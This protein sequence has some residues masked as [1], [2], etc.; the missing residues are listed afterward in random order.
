MFAVGTPNLTS[1]LNLL[2]LAT[3]VEP[4]GPIYNGPGAE[5]PKIPF[6]LRP[7]EFHEREAVDKAKKYA[8][9][10]SIRAVLLRQTQSQQSQQLNNIKKNQ[11]VALLNRVYVGSIAY[12]VK[13]DSLRQMFASFGPLKTV[14]M[15]WDPATQKHKGFAFLEFEYPEAAHLAIEQMN[16]TSF[17]GRQLKV[18][19]P[20]NLANADP[21]IADLVAEYKLQNRVYV[22]GIHLDLTEDDVAL[23][24]EAFGK[25]VFCRLLVDPNSVDRHRG[26]GYIE[27]ENTQSANDAVASMNQFNLGGQLLRV[28]KAISP[29]DGISN[30]SA[31]AL[32]P[33]AAVAAASVTAKVLSMETEQLPIN[34]TQS[35]SQ[36]N[37]SGDSTL[38]I[39]SAEIALPLGV[40]CPT[41]RSSHV[42]G[43][44]LQSPSS[45]NHSPLRQPQL[46]TPQSLCSW[47]S[48]AHQTTNASLTGFSPT[49]IPVPSENSVG[50]GKR[51][52]FVDAPMPPPPVPGILV[53][54]NMVGPEDCDDE[55]EDEVV[56]ECSQY[57]HVERVL[58]HQQLDTQTN[59]IIVKVFVHFSTYDAVQRAVEALN[60]RYFARRQIIA[61]PYDLHA[62][63]S[64]DFS[65]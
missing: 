19:R 5:K 44:Q 62:F 16:N 17:G 41:T 48:A 59:T 24:F 22:S 36:S 26:F 40:R 58:L 10:Q 15:S 9:E 61:E 37:M 11:T 65:H 2:N 50:I 30:A 35:P 4:N 47:D 1:A 57:G 3:I 49:D 43:F 8:M 29:P 42:T 20:S 25:I 28:C 33:A 18:G 54:R 53:L 21:I 52:S 60:G 32:P 64:N 38:G 27:Y 63:A 56:G 46:V 14:S 39:Y 12:D 31:S 51:S 7:L 34:A 13:E 23:V 6:S 45:L 55:L